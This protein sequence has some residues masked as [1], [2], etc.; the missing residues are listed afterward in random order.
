ML[1]QLTVHAWD[2]LSIQAICHQANVGRSTFYMHYR[3][4]EDLLSEGLNDLQNLLAVSVPNKAKKQSL[5]FVAGLLAHM[6]EHR[7][8]FKAVIGRR[9][10][11]TIERRFRQMVYQLVE[12]ELVRRKIPKAKLQLLGRFVTGGIVELMAWWVDTVK[13]PA[14][15]ELERLIQEFAVAAG[16]E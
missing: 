7:P 2:D 11:H 14:L 5:P 10:G 6:T 4:K 13:A 12:I 3:S 15:D 9:S 1:R 16:I 8:V